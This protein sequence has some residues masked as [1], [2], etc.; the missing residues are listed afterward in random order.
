MGTDL[1][2]SVGVIWVKPRGSDGLP[3]DQISAELALRSRAVLSVT[4]FPQNRRRR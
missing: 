3:L 4:I 1:H 2:P